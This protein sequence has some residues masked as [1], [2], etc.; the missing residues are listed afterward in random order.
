MI[1]EEDKLFYVIGGNISLGGL[2]GC[3]GIILDYYEAFRG[4]V[5]QAGGTNG[6]SCFVSDLSVSTL[7]QRLGV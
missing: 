1:D 6:R 4:K 2:H 3:L 5:R 7:V